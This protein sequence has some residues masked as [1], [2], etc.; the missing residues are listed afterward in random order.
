MLIFIP[1]FISLNSSYHSTLHPPVP[2]FT[3]ATDV[4]MLSSKFWSTWCWCNLTVT[5]SFWKLDQ[6]PIFYPLHFHYYEISLRVPLIWKFLLESPP[7]GYILPFS[8]NH[9]M[10]VSLP[11]LSFSGFISVLSNDGNANMLKV[12]SLICTFI[13]VQFDSLLE[14]YHFLFLYCTCIFIGQFSLWIIHFF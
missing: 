11:P 3:L 4:K 6:L 7:P 13:Y 12:S 14:H 2:S 5:H 1:P 8:H 10:S 9:F